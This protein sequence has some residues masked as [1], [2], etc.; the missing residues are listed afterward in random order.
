MFDGFRT[1]VDETIKILPAWPVEVGMLVVFHH[2]R[3]EIEASQPSLLLELD[4]TSLLETY[5]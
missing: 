3:T 2:I 1:T 5:R 4:W